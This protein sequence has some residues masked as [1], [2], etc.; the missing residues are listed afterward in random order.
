MQSF[1]YNFPAITHDLTVPHLFQRAQYL[2]FLIFIDW[3]DR[4]C[5]A[6]HDLQETKRNVGRRKYKL[7]EILKNQ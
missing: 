2:F 1:D 5:F 7:K 3:L 6:I 4:V